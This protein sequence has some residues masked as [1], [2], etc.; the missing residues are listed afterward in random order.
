[1]PQRHETQN[2]NIALALSGGG[3]RA[4]AFHLGCLRAL[5][6]RDLL[7][8]IKT[9]SSVSGGSVVGAAY[10]LMGEDFGIFEKR[11]TKLLKQGL[12][13]PTVKASISPAGA[14]WI[15]SESAVFILYAIWIVLGSALK[16]IRYILQ[17]FGINIWAG[18]R[19][20]F[21]IRRPFTRTSLLEKT[22][23]DVLYDGAKL[24]DLPSSGPKLIINATELTTGSAFRFSAGA[25]GSWRFGK[26]IGEDITLSHAVAASAA[27][28]LLLN[29]FQDRY[30]FERKDGSR[31]LS[32]VS[33]SDGGIYDNL[34][35]GPLWPDR[36]A[37]VSLNVDPCP[38]LICCSAGY[39]LRADDHPNYWMG[40]MAQSF[41][42]T[43]SRA[44][45][46]A[47]NK[48][49]SLKHTNKIE[50]LVFPYLGTRDQNI[51]NKPIDLIP[52]EQVH[53]YPTDFSAMSNKN[54]RL[55]SLRGEQ[56][57]NHLLDLYGEKVSN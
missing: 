14:L 8:N 17:M 26:V 42:T 51:P 50:T 57:T 36:S 52:R 22:L 9:I 7:R 27:Y 3:S 1:M 16:I 20:H 48:M 47:I 28:P 35:L 19:F 4:I 24:D 6:K 45:N 21:G 31:H 56:L 38:N 34:G 49:H 29:H 54:I 2:R 46:A 37:E 13:I 32:A 53:T 18:K 5:H 41:A 40:R 43:F 11:I 12:F 10:C 55:I 23:D 15:L 33:L 39:G 25:S 44:E 30:V